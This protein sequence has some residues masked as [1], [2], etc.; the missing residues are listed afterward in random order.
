MYHRWTYILAKSS[1]EL[2][3]QNN[4]IDESDRVRSGE[5]VRKRGYVELRISN[6]FNYVA[7]SDRTTFLPERTLIEAIIPLVPFV[8]M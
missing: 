7:G 8:K 6:K 2:S 5:F 1:L 3:F 4:Q